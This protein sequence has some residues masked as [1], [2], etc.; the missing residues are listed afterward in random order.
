MEKLLGNVSVRRL[1]LLKKKY[2]FANAHSRPTWR[3]CAVANALLQESDGFIEC[4][5]RISASDSRQRAPTI[6]D[7]SEQPIENN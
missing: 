7:V 1:K 3:E 4:S 6:R 5:P 2:R